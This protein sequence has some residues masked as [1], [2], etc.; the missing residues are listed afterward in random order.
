MHRLETMSL[1]DEFTTQKC[2]RYSVKLKRSQTLRNYCYQFNDASRSNEFRS[3]KISR[4]K[5]PS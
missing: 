2:D 4:Q 3:W 1:M 5:A